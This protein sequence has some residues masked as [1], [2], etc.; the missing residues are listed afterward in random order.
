MTD[1]YH[2]IP[3]G[4]I[5]IPIP[6]AIQKTSF[7]CGPAA[8][9][10]V[11]RYYGCSPEYERDFIQELRRA[12]MDPRVGAHPGQMMKAAGWLKLKTRV[13]Q[14]MSVEQ[15]QGCLRSG[16]PVALMIQAWGEVEG[17]PIRDYRALWSE[18]HWVVAIGFDRS[19]VYFEDPSLEA[20]RGYLSYD[21]LEDRWHDTGP[22]GQKIDRFG[23]A[24]W[25]PGRRI[26][27]YLRRA[28]HID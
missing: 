10:A 24:V 22:H 1:E 9:M 4:A 13:Y 16:K 18:G 17:R 23:M 21:E 15:L 5:R 26:S 11:A 3:R 25:K 20:I 6:D 14:P 27:G 2:A 8:L 7:S 12:G 28:R 19:G